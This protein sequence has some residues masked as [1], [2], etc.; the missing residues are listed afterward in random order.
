MGSHSVLVGILAVTGGTD[1]NVIAAKELRMAR[2]LIFDC[3]GE[4]TFA[5]AVT[6]QVA[7]KEGAL[8]AAHAPLR[9]SPAA[10]DVTLTAA[11]V[12]EVPDAGGWESLC[13]K[14]AATD[15]ISIPVYAVL[16][17]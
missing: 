7:M 12:V 11:R 4:A 6:V 16:G 2:K 1:T 13:L 14:C 5:G 3:S 10:A 17:T 8:F 15:T 9:L